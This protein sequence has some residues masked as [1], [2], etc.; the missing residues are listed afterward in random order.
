MLSELGDR[1]F[2]MTVEGVFPLRLI[3]IE[4]VRG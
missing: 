1:I 4:F 2:V 3:D